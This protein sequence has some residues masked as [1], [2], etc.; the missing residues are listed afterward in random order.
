MSFPICHQDPHKLHLNT[1]PNRA[2]YIPAARPGPYALEREGS[3][4]FL[5][6]NGTWDFCWFDSF[7]EISPDDP[8]RAERFGAFS[9]PSPK[10]WRP[11][12]VPAVWQSYGVDHHQYVNTRYPFPFDPPYVPRE[13][14][15]GLYRRTFIYTPRPDTP[16]VWLDFEGVD[17][18]FYL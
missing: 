9:C 10:E 4:R 3:D 16:R 6:L 2:Y 11:V 14:P 15:C 13:N 5:S 12:P 1:L 17:S 8:D 18:C 7:S